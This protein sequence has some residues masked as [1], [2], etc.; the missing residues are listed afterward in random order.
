MNERSDSKT[1]I[2]FELRIVE[3]LRRSIKGQMALF[4]C[5]V[6]FTCTVLS[7]ILFTMTWHWSMT[8]HWPMKYH[9]PIRLK[10][11]C[12]ID[13]WRG[14]MLVDWKSCIRYMH[15]HRIIYNQTA[16]LFKPPHCS[17]SVTI[18]TAWSN[19]VLLTRGAILRV[20]IVFNPTTMIYSM[21]Q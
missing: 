10:F 19:R 21:Y 13:R 12:T 17:Y 15:I 16:L 18:Q 14:S 11:L 6:L 8:W 9:D 20:Q 7:M 4:T 2:T 5:M 3:N 1:N